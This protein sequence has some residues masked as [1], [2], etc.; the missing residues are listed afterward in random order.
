MTSQLLFKDYRFLQIIDF[1]LLCTSALAASSVFL[2]ATF[3]LVAEVLDVGQPLL[4]V[5]GS[6]R[7]QSLEGVEDRPVACAAAD[8]AVDDLL[9]VRHG[10]VRFALQQT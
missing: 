3:L 7:G 2:A 6:V 10:R 1:F 4:E 5:G 9:H 8:V